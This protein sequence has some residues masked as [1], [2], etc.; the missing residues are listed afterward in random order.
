[1]PQSSSLKALRDWPSNPAA[2]IWTAP[3]IGA[4]EAAAAFIAPVQVHAPIGGAGSVAAGA[5]LGTNG[6]HQ[7]H[8]VITW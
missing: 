4:F 8:K 7:Q 5:A 3:G 1:M 6:A 2:L